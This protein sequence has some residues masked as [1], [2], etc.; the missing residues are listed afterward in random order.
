MWDNNTIPPCTIFDTI[1]STHWFYI[2]YNKIDKPSHYLSAR[3]MTLCD[4]AEI[5]LVIKWQTQWPRRSSPS[6]LV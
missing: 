5:G 2:L 3:M 6:F 4:S 1:I